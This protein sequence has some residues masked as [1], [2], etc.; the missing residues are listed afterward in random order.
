MNGWARQA[1]ARAKARGLLDVGASTEEISQL[2]RH[3]RQR[4]TAITN[5]AARYR[6]IASRRGKKR[7]IVALGHSILISAWRML[8]DDVPYQDPGGTY[9]NSLRR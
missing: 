7:A 2:L 3:A 1:A 4:T 5:L 6:R 8:T 9:V